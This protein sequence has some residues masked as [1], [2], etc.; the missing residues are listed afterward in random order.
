MEIWECFWY[1]RDDILA[2]SDRMSETVYLLAMT[3]EMYHEYFKEYQN[4]LALYE[5]EV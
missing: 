1:N 2:R 3:A 5:I 4:D